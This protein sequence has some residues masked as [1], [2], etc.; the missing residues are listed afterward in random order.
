M[1]IFFATMMSWVMSDG[2]WCDDCAYVTSPSITTVPFDFIITDLPAPTSPL[3]FVVGDVTV[4]VP[5]AKLLSATFPEW[6]GTLDVNWLPIL[7]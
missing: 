1:I 4:Y 5:V 6:V 7:G 3:I 2:L